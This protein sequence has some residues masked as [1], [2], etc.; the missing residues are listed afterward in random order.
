MRI[1]EWVTRTTEEDNGRRK[2]N[3][4]VVKT[5]PRFVKGEVVG[6]VNVNTAHVNV[7]TA[8]QYLHVNTARTIHTHTR[9]VVVGCVE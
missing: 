4:Y 9:V 1:C 7:N 8:V 5:M 2:R 6:H 3:K